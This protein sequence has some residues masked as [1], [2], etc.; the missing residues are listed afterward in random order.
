MKRLAAALLGTCGHPRASHH[1]TATGNIAYCTVWY[2][3]GIAVATHCPC[4][5]YTPRPEATRGPGG[6]EP[7]NPHPGGGSP[8]AA[9]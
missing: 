5:A 7:P 9:P 8:H 1:R 4:K 6:T 2:S 3:T